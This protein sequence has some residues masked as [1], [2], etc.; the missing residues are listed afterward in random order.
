MYTATVQFGSAPERADELTKAVFA[1][2]KELM[3]SG[4]TA[5]EL[6]K[7]KEAQ[8]RARETNLKL[9]GFWTSQLSSAYQYGDD[10]RDIL[11][12]D[13]LVDGLTAGALQ[14]AARRFLKGENYVHV[15]LL[16]ETKVP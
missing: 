11:A 6:V 3:D 15:T 13:K 14:D 1:E 2:V 16:P 9:N 7:V 12:Y 10:P 4:P 5:A 8:L